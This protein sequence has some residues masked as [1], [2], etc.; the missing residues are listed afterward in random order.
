MNFPFAFWKTSGVADFRTGLIHEWV[1]DSGVTQ[2]GGVVS[3]WVDVVGSLSASQATVGNR[4][5]VVTNELNGKA[6]VRFSGGTDQWLTF[7]SVAL[8][9]YTVVIT[10]KATS[11]QA[12]SSNYL[13]AGS[14]QGIYSAINVLGRGYGE[15]DGSRLRDTAYNAGDTTWHIRSF[16]NTKLYSNGVE[17]TYTKSQN[18]TGLTLTTIGTRSDNTTLS[19]KGDVANIRIYN[20]NLSTTDRAQVEAFLNSQYAIY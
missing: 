4:P 6:V 15:F 10:Y 8:T 20:S 19:F 5:T 9:N 16:L 12:G 11:F 3:A 7:S 18:L 1:A 17:P 2:S 14:N 13:L